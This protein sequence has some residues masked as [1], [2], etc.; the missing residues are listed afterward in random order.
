MDQLQIDVRHLHIIKFF[1]D[2]NLG[3]QLCVKKQLLSHV[4]YVDKVRVRD[5]REGQAKAAVSYP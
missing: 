5:R 3:R 1:L 2:A 4:R